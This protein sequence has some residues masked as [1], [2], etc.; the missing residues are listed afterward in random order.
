MAKKKIRRNLPLAFGLICVVLILITVGPSLYCKE[1]IPIED[2]NHLTA[3]QNQQTTNSTNITLNPQQTNNSL[4][5][6]ILKISGDSNSQINTSP[7]TEDNYNEKAGQFYNGNFDS[8]TEDMATGWTYENSSSTKIY[9]VNSDSEEGG[10]SYYTWSNKESLNAYSSYFDVLSGGYYNVNFYAKTLFPVAETGV[11]YYVVLQ[12]RNLTSTNTVQ[13]ST[14]IRSTTNW[15]RYHYSWQ[16]PEGFDYT[17]ARLRVTLLL[18]TNAFGSGASAWT[19]NITVTPK[20]QSIICSE[21]FLLDHNN[22][23]SVLNLSMQLINETNKP[24]IININDLRVTLGNNTLSV[25]SVT[26]NESTQLYNLNVQLSPI[27][28][29]K[30]MLRVFYDSQEALNFKGVNI[31]DYTGNFSFIHLTDLHYNP[32][33][34]GYEYQLNQ[35][36]QMIKKANPDFIVNTGDMG[37]SENNY[38]RFYS[39]LKSINFDIPIFFVYGNHEKETATDLTNSI[40]YMGENKIAFGNEHPIT[41][42]YGN[43]HFIG[44]DSAVFPY[45]SNGNISDSQY[46]WLKD[47]S[48]E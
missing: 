8:G 4:K 9:R 24:R 36:L 5:D 39:I 42:D 26:Y 38:Q 11:G 3:A 34:I 45:S 28:V 12:A 48:A 15:T 41:F 29:G 44:L 25:N 13:F 16:I 33:I 32:P 7:A 19:Q 2:P 27:E 6:P 22:L 21:P 17:Q 43:Y 10:Y 31:Y 23:P 20:I 30:Y 1:K 46:S 14:F 18:S 40:L 47:G 37:S 35:T